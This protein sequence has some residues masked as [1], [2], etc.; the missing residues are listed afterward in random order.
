MLNLLL[1]ETMMLAQ[2]FQ[3]LL[4]IVQFDLGSH[5]DGCDFAI[6]IDVMEGAL[7]DLL[8]QMQLAQQ[9]RLV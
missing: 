6:L 3:R 2:Q 8:D 4:R 1:E 9:G 7:L 5:L